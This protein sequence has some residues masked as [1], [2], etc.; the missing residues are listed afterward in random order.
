MGGLVSAPQASHNDIMREVGATS[1]QVENLEVRADRT[2]DRLTAIQAKVDANGALTAE[3]F[4]LLKEM[5]DDI[6]AIKAKVLAY[7]LLKA[8][9]IGGVSVAITLGSAFIAALWWAL[10]ER[11]AH[12]FK[13][14]TV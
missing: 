3:A 5:R 6:A 2:D 9:V 14:P 10:G 13:G 1:Q 11:I 8:R 12:L 7:D 4:S